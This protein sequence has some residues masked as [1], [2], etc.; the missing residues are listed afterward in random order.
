[1]QYAAGSMQQA[2]YAAGSGQ[3][4]W[5]FQSS[6]FAP[7]AYQCTSLHSATTTETRLFFRAEQ[8]ALL[9]PYLTQQQQQQSRLPLLCYP[10]TGNLRCICAREVDGELGGTPEHPAALFGPVDVEW[11]D[12]VSSHIV[13]GTGP[14]TWADWYEAFQKRWLLT[15]PIHALA[16]QGGL[17]RVRGLSSRNRICYT[18]QSSLGS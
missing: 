14:T 13:K 9:L 6:S 15:I 12:Q 5:A 11:V 18:P 17:C 7:A 3:S 8:E 16:G 2:A 4:L 10:C 1:M